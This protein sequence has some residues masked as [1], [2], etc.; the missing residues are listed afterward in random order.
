MTIGEARALAQRH[1]DTSGVTEQGQRLVIFPEDELVTDF[2]WCYMFHYN[3]ERYVE[4]NDPDSAM[5]PGRGPI[6]VVKKDGAIHELGSAPGYEDRLAE[7][8]Q[9][10]GYL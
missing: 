3:T 8:G 9:A 10:H 2:G 6:A 7:Y 1:L 5:G 4:T